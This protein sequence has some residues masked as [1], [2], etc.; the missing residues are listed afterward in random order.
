MACRVQEDGKSEGRAV[1][2][3]IGVEPAGNITLPRKR[4]D[5]HLVAHHASA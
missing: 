1:M 2:A 4:A 5:F 3:R